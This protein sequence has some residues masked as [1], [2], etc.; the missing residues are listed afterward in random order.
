MS[1]PETL[2]IDIYSDVVC[3]WCW[4]GYGQLT[5]A[6]GELGGEIEAEIRWRPFELNPDMSAEGE[7]QEIHLSRKYRR[8]AEAGAAMRGQM[9]SIAEAAGVSLSYESA[10]D[11]S[12]A[13]PPAMMW[14]TRD[15]HMLLGLA[16]EQ[17][18]PDIQTK[19]K[20]ALFAAHFNRRANLSDRG[21]LLDIAA[22]VGLHRAAAKAALDDAEL[23]ARVIAEERAAWDLNI[24]GVPAMII[25]GKFMIPGAQAPE[26]YV[27]ALR[28]VAMKTREAEAG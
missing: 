10:E 21:V 15:C 7:E 20:L 1:G 16:L 24:T 4:I 17:A 26:T 22:G 6:L 19:L 5:K 18:G 25:N 11:D 27:N 14:N 13:A 23:R 28:R 9:K 12:A 8:S 2:T 3:P